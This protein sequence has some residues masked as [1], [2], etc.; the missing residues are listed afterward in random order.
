M[1]YLIVSLN[2]LFII[3]LLIYLSNKNKILLEHTS[4]TIRKIHSKP[5]VKIGGLV[6]IAVFINFFFIN[7]PLIKSIIIFGIFFGLIGLIAD[8]KPHFSSY[9]R[10]IIMTVL[11][12]Y[13][14]INNMFIIINFDDSYITQ[15]FL[16]VPGLA[17]IFSVIGLMLSINGFNFIDGN[18]GLLLGV[19]IL[20]LM[21][22]IYHAA[23]VPDL[24]MFLQ[25]LIIIASIL[26]FFNFFYGNIITGDVGSYYIGFTIGCVAILQ[27][28]YGIINSPYEI[29][30]IIFYPIMEVVLTF[31]RRLFINKT[32]P[33]YP[34]N[35]HMH[36][37]IFRLLKMNLQSWSVNVINS[38]TS[39]LI[40]LSISFLLSFLHYFGDDIGYFNVF[41]LFI[42][43][44]LIVYVQLYSIS[45]KKLK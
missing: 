5:V 18:N 1:F 23:S 3:L 15:L 8:L 2:T 19:S 27:K 36:S 31:I 42:I 33:F 24:L 44:Y 11:L 39:L 21:Y 14:V 43:I 26:F 32:A 28:N 37:I 7:D 41:V 38:L 12:I 4:K 9:S 25:S 13:F 45:K 34:D 29:A 20:I 35:L 17:I 10:F 16:N 30:C 6:F 22:F 40:L